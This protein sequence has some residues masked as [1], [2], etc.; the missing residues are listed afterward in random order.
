ML[1]FFIFIFFVFRHRPCAGR[2]AARQLPEHPGDS[3][4]DEP[5]VRDP[6]EEAQEARTEAA[7]EHGRA[8][9]CAGPAAGTLPSKLSLDVSKN[10]HFY[11][12]P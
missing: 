11:G 7:E 10:M 3:P 6:A 4:A 5:V 1:P 2:P 9:C 8:L 12:K